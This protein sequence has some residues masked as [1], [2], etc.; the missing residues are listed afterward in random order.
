MQHHEPPPTFTGLQVEMRLAECQ[1][2]RDRIDCEIQLVLDDLGELWK[3][4]MELEARKLELQEQQ[5]RLKAEA[6]AALGDRFD[7]R[8]FHAQV[9]DTGALP[10]PVLEAKLR[11]WVGKK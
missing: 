3:E 4:M 1:E 9:L 6:K 2:Q 8:E 5:R 10:M 11:A 7:P